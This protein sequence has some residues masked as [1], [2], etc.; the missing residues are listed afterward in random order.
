MQEEAHRF[1]AER[2]ERGA[3]IRPQAGLGEEAAEAEQ[4]RGLGRAKE[5]PRPPE[6][7]SQ[8]RHSGKRMKR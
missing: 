6:S 5:E 1:E 4:G 2:G 8:N 7:S 3:G